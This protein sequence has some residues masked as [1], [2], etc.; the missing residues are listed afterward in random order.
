M[1]L[2]KVDFFPPLFFGIVMDEVGPSN[3]V[4]RQG[5]SELGSDEVS[6]V[7]WRPRQL[8]FGPFSPRNE[9]EKNL[10]VAVRRP[11]SPFILIVF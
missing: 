11:V 5:T 8:V 7:R 4:E 6:V 9:A 3:Q 2:E 10:R 1:G